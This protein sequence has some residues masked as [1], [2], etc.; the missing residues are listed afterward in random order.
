MGDAPLPPAPAGLR[1]AAAVVRRLPFG[2]YHAAW[3]AGRLWRGPY[4]VRLPAALG[5]AVFHCDLRDAIAREVCF[6]GAYG[7][8][9]TALLR[10]LLRPGAT[11]V[12]VGANWGYFTLLAAS[13][14]GASGRVVALEPDPRLFP[15]LAGNAARNRLAHAEAVPVAA[16]D[17]AGEA[18]LAGFDERQGNWGLST[19]A[20]AGQ[21]GDAPVFRVRTERIDTL[22]D[23]RG[24]E[25]ADLLKMDVEG[26]EEAALR[27][28][29]EGIARHRYRAVLLELHPGLVDDP[30]RLFTAVRETFGG[31][32]YRGWTVDHS[33]AATRRA[34]YG[35]GL[36]ARDFLR[37]LEVAGQDAWPH[38]LW[39]A[40]GGWKP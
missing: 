35:R 14:T 11:F 17:T 25:S 24:M 28:M 10:A 39:T 30:A 6:T 3:R 27:G 29:A 20:A 22:M 5:G 8:Q 1:A 33:P 19:L 18:L 15:L 32:G 21:G 2:R 9:E 26:A 4:G 7:H 23:E 38:Q 13:L 40:P 16:S 37:P 36:A 34:A 31:A 12:D